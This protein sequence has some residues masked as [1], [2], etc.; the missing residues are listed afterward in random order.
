M[1][2]WIIVTHAIDSNQVIHTAQLLSS[3]EVLQVAK[4]HLSAM[5]VIEIG[6]D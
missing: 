5:N 6:V 1:T 2:F 4:E 3:E